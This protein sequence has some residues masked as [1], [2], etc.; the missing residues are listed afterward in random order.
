MLIKNVELLLDGKLSAVNVFSEFKK[1]PTTN[2]SSRTNSGIKSVRINQINFYN[3][4]MPVQNSYVFVVIYISNLIFSLPA[5]HIHI[6]CESNI[7][8]IPTQCNNKI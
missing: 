7:R 2:F 5:Y 3:N 4:K 1:K 6:I 8:N